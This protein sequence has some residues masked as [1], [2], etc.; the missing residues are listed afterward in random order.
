MSFLGDFSFYSAPNHL[1]INK[2][3]RLTS[4]TAEKE[5]HFHKSRGRQGQFSLAYISCA[6][7]IRADIEVYFCFLINFPFVTKCVRFHLSPMLEINTRIFTECTILDLS[8]RFE[9]LV[10]ELDTCIGF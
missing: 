7:E 2:M 6:K 1:N 10:S 9:T 5:F 4:Q 8:D 3:T